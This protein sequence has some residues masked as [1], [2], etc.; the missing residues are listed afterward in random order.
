MATA[1]RRRF[2]SISAY[3]TYLLAAG[4]SARRVV[5]IVQ[6]RR[7]T[8]W[9]AA[10]RS[11]VAVDSN[12]GGGQHLVVV[13]P[14]YQEQQ[15]AENAAGYWRTLVQTAEVDE[16]MFVTTA[17]ELDTGRP[18]TQA[19]LAAALAQAREPR[20]TL[21]HCTPLNPFRAAP[22]NPPTP[23]SRHRYASTHSP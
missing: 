16:V 5:E 4:L 1:T 10:R 8:A 6:G 18:T 13:V 12:S 23:T 3:A 14:M 19:L 20:L 22:F 9:S 21:L 2:S 7:C 17:K 11:P 15:I